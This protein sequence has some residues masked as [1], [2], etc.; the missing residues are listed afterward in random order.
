MSIREGLI[1]LGKLTASRD[2]VPGFSLI[3]RRYNSGPLRSLASTVFLDLPVTTTRN[4]KQA[5]RKLVESVLAAGR[6]GRNVW[7]VPRRL[8]DGVTAKLKLTAS[9]ETNDLPNYFQ[10]TDAEIW[11]S[12]P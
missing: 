1:V 8:S 3:P 10:D 5:C 12:T 7:L 4:V 6:E 2:S 11:V 9:A